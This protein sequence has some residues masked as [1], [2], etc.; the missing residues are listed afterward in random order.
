MTDVTIREL[1]N[2]G[3]EVVARVTAGEVLTVTRDGRPVAR[4]SPIPTQTLSAHALMEQICALHRA[5]ITIIVITHDMQLVADYAESVVVLQ[6]GQILFAG[7]APAL[8]DNPALLDRASLRALPLHEL[9]RAMGIEYTD[10]S[11][12]LTIREWFPF[13]GLEVESGES[14]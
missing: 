3:G 4:L 5:G 9:A 11:S 7:H 8:F 12:P 13:F 10:G 2:K 14:G 1:R 6:G